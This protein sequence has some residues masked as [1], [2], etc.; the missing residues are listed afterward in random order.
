MIGVLKI[1]YADRIDSDSDFPQIHIDRQRWLEDRTY[2][3]NIC[4]TAGAHT[5]ALLDR[6]FG[7]ARTTNDTN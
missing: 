2:R 6:C 5:Y 3:E 4:A 7:T 1:K